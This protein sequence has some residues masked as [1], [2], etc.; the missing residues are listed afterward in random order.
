MAVFNNDDLMREIE[1]FA[2]G[3]SA[4][5]KEIQIKLDSMQRQLNSIEEREF[6]AKHWQNPNQFE[7][8]TMKLV[9]IE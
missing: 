7:F 8:D 6:T 3:M 2:D 4:K 9:K 1:M 5:L